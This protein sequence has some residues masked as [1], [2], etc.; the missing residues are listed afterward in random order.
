VQRLQFEHS[1]LFI[2]LCLSVGVGYAFVL[3]QSKSP[4]SKRANQALFGLRAGLVTLLCFLLIGPILKLITN[5][6]EKPSYVF[7]I[8][9][10]KSISEIIDST[11]LTKIKLDLEQAAD[12]LKQ[13][14]FEVKWKSL[15]NQSESFLFNQSQSDLTSALRETLADYE[16][17]NLSGI[18]LVSDGLY[19]SG[20]SPLYTPLSVAVNT[21]GIG[22][23]T[24]RA[25]LILKN[26]EYNKIAYQ[27][28][29]FPIRAEVLIQNL[30]NQN[31]SIR[32]L[33]NGKVIEQQTKNSETKTALA[34]DFLLEASEK[35]M[36]RLE[37]V[38]EVLSTETNL[39]NNRASIFVEVVEGKKKVLLVAP[40]PH[41][42][43]KAIRAVVEKNSNYEFILHI[44]GVAEADAAMLKPAGV[45]LAIFY[46]AAD[47]FGKT[48]SLLQQFLKSKT[49]VWIILGNQS[50]LRQLSA[51]AIPLAF[52]NLGQTD[53]VTPIINQSF[54]DF[55]FQENSNGIFARYPPAEVPF[56]KFSFPSTAN[57][58]L[59]QRIG[60]VATD[61]PLLFTWMDE[62]RKLAALVGEG[63]WK[64]RLHE[65]STTEKTEM[66]DDV[67]LKLI[68][69]L[70]TQEDKRKFR[71]FPVQN[72]FLESQSVILESQVY[73]DLYETVFGN[74]IEIELKDETGNTTRYDYVTSPG[75]VRYQI[76]GLK[77]GV[78]QYKASTQI[79]NQREEVRGQFL[80][81][82]A[83]LEEQNLTADFG[84]LRKLSQANE[85]KFYQANNLAALNNDFQKLEAKSLI[86]SD[87]SFNPLIN[88]KWF[89][90]LLLLVVSGE[91]FLRKYWGG[92]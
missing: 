58:L 7:L 48:T 59:Y 27:G 8:D 73:N 61:R 1:P 83:T 3:Y 81:T 34:I 9:N 89:F 44:P 60:S 29:K 54:R 25:D 76:G 65:F 18:T 68:Q 70:S 38:V 75:G 66:F 39:K 15:S 82:A 16:G 78:Y 46:Q 55:S 87:E 30:P 24:A 5:Q 11:R 32:I 84:L 80:V 13:Q 21:V 10:S 90:F 57:I 88:L 51:N 63:I 42:D 45:E 72:E 2:I 64:W 41:P 4:W 28:N 85:G 17:K 67:F 50:N 52:D 35:G 40:S 71:C 14:G 74:K 62:N 19:N 77:E 79:N 37:V 22:D 20:T 6:V 49:S 56:G 92:Y 31:I 86:H 91:W 47:M 26:V 43:I 53:E 23:T 12:A 33:K 36:Q 69:Y